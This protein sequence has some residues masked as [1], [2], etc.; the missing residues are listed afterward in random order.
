RFCIASADLQGRPGT[1]PP[2]GGRSGRGAF[3]RSHVML[4]IPSRPLATYIDHTLLRPE[5]PRAAYEALAAEAAA[6]GFAAIC[7]PPVWLGPVAAL[8]AGTSVR[9]CTVIA[10]PFGY[11]HP[12]ARREESSRAIEGGAVEL[13]TVIDVSLLKGGEGDRAQD[14]LSAWVEAAR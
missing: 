8:L 10:F 12:A 2:P 14:D 9:P 5:A 6:H 4:P 3:P 7:V 1:I 11:V 13:D